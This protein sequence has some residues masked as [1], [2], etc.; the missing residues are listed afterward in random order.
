MDI[1]EKRTLGIEIHSAV[2]LS[3]CGSVPVLLQRDEQCGQ[4]EANKKKKYQVA[5]KFKM[6]SRWEEAGEQII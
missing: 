5:Q 1:Q 2:C 4:G 6:G 3:W